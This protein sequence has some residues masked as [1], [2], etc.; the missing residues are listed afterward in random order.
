MARKVVPG[1]ITE[2]YKIGQ[3][4]F[5][6]NLVGQ[7]FTQGTPLFTLGNFAITTNV[8]GSE[9][10]TVYQTGSFSDVYTLQTL[11]L[12]EQESEALSNQSLEIKLN[13]DTTNLERFVY[14][15]SFYEF[16]SS[17]IKNILLNWKGS[18]Y[19]NPY[20]PNDITGIARNTV[21]NYTYD[22]L[23]NEA[24]FK[25]PVSLINNKFGLIY[26]SQYGGISNENQ[27]VLFNPENNF[28]DMF[29][30]N[31]DYRKYQISNIF[32]DF[33]VKGFTGSTD[34]N[35]YLSITVDGSPWP[36]LETIGFGIFD[37][38]VRPKEE[39]LNKFFF[40]NLN[41]FESKILNR[42]TNPKYTYTLRTT[43]KTEEGFTFLS[44]K[45]FTW[46]TTDGYNIDNGGGE[47]TAYLNSWLNAAKE[48]DEYKTDLVAR[49]FITSSIIEFDTDGG[50]DDVYGR[51]VNKLLRIYGREFDEIKKHIDSLSFSRIVEYDKKDNTPDSMIKILA[52]EL[53]FDVLL[54]FFENNLF[55]NDTPQN[56]TTEGYGNLQLVPF[57]GYSRNLSVKEM[58]IE[59]WRRLVI[60][61]WWLFRS[62]GHRKV[63]EFFL[64][65]FGIQKCVVS[66]DE[67]IYI[68]KDAPLDVDETVRL[69]SEIS[70]LEPGEITISPV[71]DASVPIDVYGFP[72]LP[73]NSDEYYFQQ[74]GFWYNGGNLSETGNNPHVGPYD[75]G[76]AYL[77]ALR[78]FVEGYDGVTTGTTTFTTIDNLFTDYENG[79]IE[80]GLS[81][82]GE[83]YAEIMNQNN[84]STPDLNISLAGSDD[85]ITYDESNQ[86]F[87]I[88]FNTFR[89]DC[90]LPCPVSY[91]NYENGLIF[92]GS[93]TPP[94]ETSTQEIADNNGLIN[95]SE[96]PSLFESNPET[97]INA[98]TISEVCCVEAGGYYLPIG[99]DENPLSVDTFTP[100][101]LFSLSEEGVDQNFGCYWCPP[102][103]VICGIDYYNNLNGPSLR[104]EG[105]GPVGGGGGGDF[106]TGI[107]CTKP[108]GQY[109]YEGNYRYLIVSPPTALP[110]QNVTPI[111]PDYLGDQWTD[112]TTTTGL[113]FGYNNLFQ[114]GLCYGVRSEIP[115]DGDGGTQVVEDNT[116][117]GPGDLTSNPCF[118]EVTQSVDGIW[119]INGGDARPECCT[120]NVIG[121]P[122]TVNESG[123]CVNLFADVEDCPQEIIID[124][125]IV[126]TIEKQQ[127]CS[128]DVVGSDV[129]W[130]GENCRVVNE[131]FCVILST[132]GQN[133]TNE[134]CCSLKGGYLST[135]LNGNIVCLESQPLV[136]EPQPE[137]C[138]RI[139]LVNITSE[140]IYNDDNTITTIIND[141]NGNSLSEVC[142][143]E[144]SNL[145]NDPSVTYDPILG[146]C[147]KTEVNNLVA[148]RYDLIEGF[149]GRV[150]NFHLGSDLGINSLH[151]RI[152]LKITT[153]K[154]DGIDY[155][156]NTVIQTIIDPAIQSPNYWNSVL[157]LQKTINDLN[158]NNFKI[159]LPGE[160]FNV[161]PSVPDTQG[162]ITVN[163]PDGYGF[164]I[165]RPEGTIFE[166]NIQ[167][168]TE[169]DQPGNLNTPPGRFTFNLTENT[170]RLNGESSPRV[171][172][173]ECGYKVNVEVD[174][175]GDTCYTIIN[176]GSV[177]QIGGGFGEE[178][179][180]CYPYTIN[181][182]TYN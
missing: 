149:F 100:E 161:N 132:D 41:E 114:R 19:I 118:G 162:L 78:C 87:R 155:L 27:N 53:G 4:D 139:E 68:A 59:L 165:L 54:S 45:K 151:E 82:Y 135:D 140:V 180:Q 6:P 110:P 70:N 97:L 96:I 143:T 175:S 26:E 14:F 177:G 160:P 167:F 181:G 94:T 80:N 44:N 63:L 104:Q 52:G 126:I 79:T 61:A 106:D 115:T 120:E 50:G 38:H 153:L 15:G 170:Q 171:R 123:K 92:I 9:F 125:D 108:V 57:S 136:N 35:P 28:G 29:N 22:F 98:A 5:S 154:I 141:S 101:E 83:D 178:P 176:D 147:S 21:L 3:G 111:D 159:Q 40:N 13:L 152:Y 39:Y 8:S 95:Q 129:F 36:G 56:S 42:L 46:P 174:T 67:Y 37:Y 77:N 156:N 146:I 169:S 121:L 74:N 81:N 128:R 60:N 138:S 179:T 24:T 173:T 182:N 99:I 107:Y 91:I 66:L 73:S 18:L 109:V 142:C 62:K 58:D 164:Y 117:L 119:L 64:N 75:Y 148:C 25:I 130:D 48:L 84:R 32:G 2:P 72:A 16:I 127:C 93:S 71:P 33:F 20:I 88:T 90:V 145:S 105:A 144:Y 30:L 137:S 102:T 157:F 131:D 12:T 17:T 113:L 85:T 172:E 43:K 134:E 163:Y 23:N 166:I 112:V 31:I 122:V 51:K 89:E 103:Y 76:E 10:S 158:I 11:N 133:I 49:R 34:T 168:Y 1:S 86:S 150:S 47:F 124:G 7:Q 116:L 69:V 65:L 55:N